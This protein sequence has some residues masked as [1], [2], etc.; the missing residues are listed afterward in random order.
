MEH[1]II[2]ILLLIFAVAFEFDFI[3]K[4]YVKESFT[5]NPNIPEPPFKLANYLADKP[6]LWI[7]NPTDVS[8]R[9]WINF[10]SRRT[11]QPTLPLHN[12]CINSIKKYNNS[13]FNIIVFNETHLIKILPEYFN[14]TEFLKKFNYKYTFESFIKYAI[15]LKHGGY[16]IPRDTIM[17]KSLKPTIPFFNDGLCLSFLNNNYNYID[18]EGFNDSYIACKPNNLIIKNCL[19]YILK[20]LYNFQNT[21]NFKLAMNKIFN[22]IVSQVPSAHK[23]FNL[24]LNKVGNQYLNE[25]ILFSQND[26]ELDTHVTFIPIY[27]DFIHYKTKFNWV[28]RMSESDILESSL[29]FSKLLR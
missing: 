28:D 10:G 7:Y 21:F 1:Y 23:H 19:E 13:D 22:I 26:I 25:E 2:L 15:L 16:W 29:L 24:G 27:Y 18:N 3:K 4:W 11:K 9:D 14:D 17:V 12:L 5:S 6:Y 8:T 20:N